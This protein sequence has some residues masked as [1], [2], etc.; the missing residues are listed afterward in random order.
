M[1]PVY[2]ILDGSV[3]R[4][5]GFSFAAAAGAVLAGGLRLL[6]IRWKDTWTSSVYEDAGQVRTLCSQA[7]AELVINDRPDIA[8][9]LD[10]GVHVGQ[11][12]IS[13][14]EARNIAG[15][16]RLLGH[17]THNEAQFREALDGP[18]DY[19]AL[20]PV[21]ATT[22]KRN[23]DPTVGLAELARLRSASSKPVVAIGGIT[24]DRAPE[25]W[26]SG[27]D[28]VALISDLYP[29]GCTLSSIQSRAAEWARIA[30]HEHNYR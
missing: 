8:R 25:V 13:P 11:D 14:Q 26:R 15:P 23:P 20:G 1:Q 24:L 10:A 12:D 18:A 16:E 7:G 6:Q 30:L 22:S 2:A 9:L 3:L 4:S 17:S 5:R 29:P 21:Y 19:V 27:A 28:S